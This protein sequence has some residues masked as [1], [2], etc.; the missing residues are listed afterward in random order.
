M[1]LTQTF[2][3]ELRRALQDRPYSTETIDTVLND[4]TQTYFLERQRSGL[5]F[6]ELFEL[7]ETYAVHD[8]AVLAG[9]LR[10]RRDALP[11]FRGAGESAGSALI[12]AVAS[13]PLASRQGNA[14]RASLTKSCLDRADVDVNKRVRLLAWLGGFHN[15]GQVLEQNAVGPPHLA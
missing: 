13:G 7:A 9:E 8:E 15:T 12:D 10:S 1:S 3:N 11:A 14:L 4:V 5:D 6:A 2:N